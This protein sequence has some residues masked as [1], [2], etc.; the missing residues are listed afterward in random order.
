MGSQGRPHQIEEG[1]KKKEVRAPCKKEERELEI[2][3]KLQHFR[4]EKSTIGN[5]RNPWHSQVIFKQHKDVL[6]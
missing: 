1:R 2:K 6:Q 5:Q 3:R 4:L